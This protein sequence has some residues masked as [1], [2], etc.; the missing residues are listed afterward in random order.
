VRRVSGA[1]AWEIVYPASVLR[2]REDL[3]EVR[4]MLDA[5]EIDA[6]IDELRWLLAG[7]RQLLEAHKLLG[8]IALADGDLALARAHFGYAYQ[9]GVDALR[10]AKD[11][12]GPLPYALEANQPFLEAGKGLAYCLKQQDD[13]QAA[14]QV[15]QR[16][17]EL[18]PDDPL[19]LREW[20]RAG[21]Q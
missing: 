8:E 6:A 21:E 2:R 7:C 12:A 5:G 15:A 1:D 13:A 18:D 19:K 17:L 4:S 3:D 9:M 20:I 16:L 14:V 11:F 10:Q